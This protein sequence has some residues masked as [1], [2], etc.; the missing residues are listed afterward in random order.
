MKVV[1][2]SL[3]LPLPNCSWLVVAMQS[4]KMVSMKPTKKRK[5]KYFDGSNQINFGFRG[6]NPSQN[7]TE[8]ERLKPDLQK[9]SCPTLHEILLSAAAA[10]VKTKPHNKAL[11]KS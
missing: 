7:E 1:I 9:I 11:L 4:H 6:E 10:T 8:V 2:C 5:Q 3:L